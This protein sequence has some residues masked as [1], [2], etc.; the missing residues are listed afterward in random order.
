MTVPRFHIIGMGSG[1]GSACVGHIWRFIMSCSVS[2]IRSPRKLRMPISANAIHSGLF[3][4]RRSASEIP[5]RLRMA[6][7]SIVC[8]PLAWQHLGKWRA[9]QLSLEYPPSCCVIF[10]AAPWGIRLPWWY[11]G[12]PLLCVVD[13]TRLCVSP[14]WCWG[15][16]RYPSS[17]S[18]CL[19]RY[20]RTLSIWL[21]PVNPILLITNIKLEKEWD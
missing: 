8:Q 9:R 6:C 19:C 16:S 18:P 17:H 7:W 4:A 20:R 1:W 2:V 10:Q 13:N 21:L 14:F 15:E 3:P 5:T 11:L 12:M